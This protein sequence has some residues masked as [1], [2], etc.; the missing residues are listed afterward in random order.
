MPGISSVPQDSAL[1]GVAAISK[2]DAWAVGAVNGTIHQPLIEHWNGQSWQVV[3]SPLLPIVSMLKSV[4]MLSHDDV[5]AVGA[6]QD[7]L[8][9]VEHWDGQSWQVVTV[10]VGSN[11]GYDTGSSL[12]SIQALSPRNIYIS[13]Q[14]WL[15]HWDGFTW[16]IMEHPVTGVSSLSVLASDEIWASSSEYILPYSKPDLMHMAHWNGQ[17]WEFFSLPVDDGQT[18]H[19]SSILA[20]H[21][22][23][24]WIVD[25]SAYTN[26]SE[27]SHLTLIGHWN[28]QTWQQIPVPNSSLGGTALASLAA[29]SSSDVWAV[30][31]MYEPPSQSQRCPHHA[32]IE[33]WNGTNWQMVASPNL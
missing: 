27:H 15:E 11:P 16:Q 30:G 22:D 14:N 26:E 28:G 4:S 9:L 17:H 21:D 20:I 6:T 7:G 2:D 3:N 32:I 24:V 5:W 29:S 8:P 23:D 19:V 18:Y 25:H 33:H 12:T 31:S 10:P 13:G 1:F